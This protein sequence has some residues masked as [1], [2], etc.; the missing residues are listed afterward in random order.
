MVRTLITPSTQVGLSTSPGKPRALPGEAFVPERATPRA[1]AARPRRKG[2]RH[3]LSLPVLLF[4]MTLGLIL[5]HQGGLVEYFFPLGAFGVALVL[6]WRSPAHYIGFVCWLF[7]LTP[8]VRRL[9]DFVNGSFNQQSP[10]MVATLLAV[11][12]TGLTLLKHVSLLGQRRA[13]PLV[14]IV[15]ALLYAFVVGMAQVGPAAATFTLINWLYPVM[16]AFYLTVTWRHY[17]DYHRVLLKTF[18]YGGLL[19]SLYGLLEFVSPM[20][21][22]AFWLISSKMLSEG[23]PVPFGMRVSST[24]NSCGP[25]A[26]TL[27]TILLM[28]LAARGKARIVL[29]CVGVPV[30]LLTS[31]RSTWGGFAIALVYSF[32]MLDGKSRRRLM[33]GVLGLA[34]VA[35]PLMMI[36]QVA[37]PVLQRLSTIQ[38]LGK[39]DSYQARAEFYK[40]FMSSALTDI[41][42]QGLGTTGLGSKLSDDTASQARLNFD[43][44]LMEVPFVMGWPGTLLYTTGIV[45]LLWRAYRASRQHPTDLLA[46]SGVGVAVAIFSM[47]VFINTLTAVSGMFFFLGVTLPVIS[48]RYARER[49]GAVAAAPAR[50]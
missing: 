12:L 22:D 32:V 28:S 31:A 30:L 36:D 20:P 23:Q 49:H 21:W 40:S 43:S 39:D 42:G 44:G 48:L 19:M 41:A 45:M 46:V 47:M 27:M 2:L 10:I 14:L 17:P 29:G 9:A 25:F 38:D 37:E 4:A 34:V 7:F 35:A 1:P 5:L 33:A 13:A 18:V 50:F 15:I 24:M 26:V 16:V 3:P 6:Y 8:E 11:S